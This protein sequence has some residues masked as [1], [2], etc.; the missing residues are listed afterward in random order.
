MWECCRERNIRIH[1]GAEREFRRTADSSD[2]KWHPKV[3]Q[4]LQ[5]TVDVDLSAACHNTLLLQLNF[6]SVSTLLHI[7]PSKLGM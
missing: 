4:R 6:V 1:A 2:W 7:L 5:S 3:F